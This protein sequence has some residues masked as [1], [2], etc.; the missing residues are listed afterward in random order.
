MTG[1]NSHKVREHGQEWSSRSTS[2]PSGKWTY[3]TRSAAKKHAKRVGDG[4][5]PYKCH[6]CDLW[7]VGH[8]PDA[9]M[10]G[11]MS[12]SEFHARRVRYAYPKD[13]AGG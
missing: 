8:K 6:A 3:L 9:T 2:C 11:E 1:Q 4:L 5:R 13:Q 10:R 12:A 7:H